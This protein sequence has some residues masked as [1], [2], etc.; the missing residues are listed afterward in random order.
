MSQAVQ[1]FVIAVFI[2]LIMYRLVV[3]PLTQMSRT[4]TEF[5][6]DKVPKAIHLRERWFD[7]EMSI[8][9]N[10]YNHSVEQIREHY[11]QLEDAREYAEE[12]NRKKKR[13][14]GKYEP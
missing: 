8:L 6:S 4:V 2:I 10:S 3:Q 7:D 13:V 12:A 11:C 14:F 5:D 1:I 9:S